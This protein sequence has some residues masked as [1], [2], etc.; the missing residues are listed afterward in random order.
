MDKLKGLGSVLAVFALIG[1]VIALPELFPD[2]TFIELVFMVAMV[3]A[4]LL[5]LLWCY[6]WVTNEIEAKKRKS[7]SPDELAAYD[8]ELAENA[9]LV[10][11]QMKRAND[12]HY[13]IKKLQKK[14]LREN[15]VAVDIDH[16]F[17]IG[18]CIIRYVVDVND[19][20]IYY[21]REYEWKFAALEFEQVSGVDIVEGGVS[22]D[23]VGNAILGGLVG[24][25]VGAVVGSNVANDKIESFE[26]VI[27]TK[28]IK[29]PL[30]RLVLID[31]PVFKDSKKYK[32][33]AEFAYQVG[34]SI[35]A[36]V[37]SG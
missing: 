3:L 22:T 17:D 5:F 30:V 12:K 15:Y 7:M 9:K 4:G 21:T 18:D 25:G 23:R 37:A 2:R 33:A 10:K 29:A 1:L 24:G 20:H 36:I 27:H 34:A 16:I 8:R 31:A 13:D 32:R 6:I 26:I 11:K 14:W 35:R 19:K 28:N